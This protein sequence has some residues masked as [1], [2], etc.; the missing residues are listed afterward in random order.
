MKRILI[1]L[2]ASILILSSAFGGQNETLTGITSINGP[3]NVA[4]SASTA[5]LGTVV[6]DAV[7]LPAA[8]SSFYPTTGA[9]GAKGV[10]IHPKDQV[11]GRVICIGNGT[12]ASVLKIYPPLGGT[13]N[14]AAANVAFSSVAA[15]GVI[16]L[17]CTSSSANTWFAW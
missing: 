13:I 12:P 6:G 11:K 15:R 14:G 16:T 17:I 10:K 7:V 5:A 1:S 4:V 9:D 8:T 3:V 2:F